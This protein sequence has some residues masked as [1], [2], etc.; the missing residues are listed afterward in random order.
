MAVYLGTNG[1]VELQ[2]DSFRQALVTDLDPADVN[3]E[4]RRFSVD[5]A[6]GALIT[7]DQIDI[8]TADG[9][10]LELVADHTD[11][12]GNYFPDW[13]GYVY[14]DDA[15][16]MRLYDSFEKSLQGD[17]SQALPLIEPSETKRV[18][19]STR[20]GAFRCLAQVSSF[21]ITTTRDEVDITAL[22]AEFRDKYE[23]GLISGQGSIECFW[24]HK[25]SNEECD[26]NYDRNV[27]FPA[28]LA[29]LILRLQQG[30]DFNGRFYIYTGDNPS[31]D[32]SVWYEA[33]CIVT[34]VSVAVEPTQIITT[35]INF[36]TANQIVL[37]QG[38]PPVYLLQEDTSLIL[39]ESSQDG[40]LLQED[41]N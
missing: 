35:S 16:G 32:P 29:R 15:G 36:V 25:F 5:F 14:I 33:E 1:H 30:S 9:T 6:E 34:N 18:L 22:G 27:E 7:G 4:R 21:E 17:F 19:F 38:I 11:P 28:Y 31:E 40:A 26:P 24:E 39:L 20:S 41:P 23:A 37:H 8:A 2:R 3:V 12:D 13:R 10:A